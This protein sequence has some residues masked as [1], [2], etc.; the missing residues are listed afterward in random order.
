M[1]YLTL[2]IILTW[3]LFGGELL[4]RTRVLMGTYATVSLPSAYNRQINETFKLITKI[5]HAL[6]T[7]DSNATLARLNH[8]HRIGYDPVLACALTLSRR[9]Y[10]ET[11]GY[12]DI[13]VGSITKNLYR[14]GTQHPQS[15]DKQAL[16]QAKRNIDGFHVGKNTIT[17]DPGIIL[18]LGGMGK[19][20]AVDEAAQYLG[21]HNITQGMVGLSG[22]IRCLD[23]CELYLQSPFDEGIFAKII[24]KIPHLSVSTSG[25]YRRY[26]TKKSE[27][28]LINPKT[29]VQGNTFVSV[30]LITQA[31]N[32]RI[33]AYATAVSVM[34]K[35]KALTFLQKHPDIGYI[36]VEPDGHIIKG[37]LETFA[38]VQT[39]VDL[40]RKKNHPEQDNK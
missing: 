13:T 29:A 18:D 33:D 7:F 40:Q 28:H 30:T 36:L 3:E 9:Y 23:R 38:T 11:D 5:E 37:G 39:L 32:T 6:S 17:S 22:D 31:D 19:G 26:A 20:F 14:F 1:K 2:L 25:T 34:P 21:E 15:P 27:H 12:F 4:T 24:S 10:E 8:A 16:R 35:D